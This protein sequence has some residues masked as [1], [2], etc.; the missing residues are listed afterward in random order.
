[1]RC[2]PD[3]GPIGAHRG[4]RDDNLWGDAGSDVLYGG[5]GND[6]LRG[7]T[8]VDEFI[9]ESANGHDNIFDFTN[10]QDLID[11]SAYDLSGYGDVSATRMGSPH[12]LL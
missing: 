8:G 11:L 9:F 12:K 5:A 1:M 6:R 4:T 10:G 2:S 3:P 7:G